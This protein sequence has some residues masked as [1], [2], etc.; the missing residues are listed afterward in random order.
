MKDKKKLMMLSMAILPLLYSSIVYVSFQENSLPHQES[1]Q[2]NSVHGSSLEH[3]VWNT[4]WGGIYTEYGL[5]IARDG[6]GNLIGTGETTSTGDPSGDLFV[7]KFDSSGTKLWNTTWE[8]SGY[9]AGKGVDVD[10]EGYIYVCGT[11][12][13]YGGLNDVALIKYY[14]NGTKLQETTYGGPNMENG[15]GI[16]VYDSSNIY[17]IGEVWDE[18][19]GSFDLMLIK[20]NLTLGIDWIKVW[21]GSS[22]DYGT[23]VT[24]DGDGNVYCTGYTY[25]YGSGGRDFVV[26][27]Y[28]SDGNKVWDAVWGGGNYD[29]S[30]RIVVDGDGNV[31]CVGE[32]ESYGSGAEDLVLVKFDKDGNELWYRMWGG[33]G[34]DWGKDLTIDSNGNIYCVGSSNSFLDSNYHDIIIVGFNPAGNI[35]WNETWGWSSLHPVMNAFYDYGQ[36]I[37][38]DGNGNIFVIG[39]THK[40]DPSWSDVAL[41][42]FKPE[43]SGGD[44]SGGANVPG[45]MSMHVLL[46]LALGF[47][48]IL[49]LSR[50][51]FIVK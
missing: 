39:T 30:Y 12:D 21:G 50:K 25:S 22:G 17:C 26:I 27:K 35:I 49:F 38:S 15:N 34:N 31:Y 37:T 45:F 46:G 8:G 14:P 48:G 9:E 42:A 41:L 10:S 28:D 5:D 32:T 43:L 24:V 33:A 51:N 16:A 19:N 18:S 11:T 44:N 7:V 4:T 3:M 1:M 6:D 20:F 29:S 40:Y 13:S 2:N 36:G 47:V 23:G